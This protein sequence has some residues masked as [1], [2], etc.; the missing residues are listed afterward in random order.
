[1]LLALA[2]I[3]ARVPAAVV[4]IVRQEWQDS[5]RRLQEEIRR[6]RTADALL[7][8]VDVITEELRRRIGQSFTLEEL[9]DAYRGAD[10]WSRDAVAERAPARGLLPL[11]AIVEGA[12]FHLYSRGAIDFRP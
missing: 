5:Y 11:F 1:M 6:P 4:D 8:Q 2:G 12:A 10:A 9:A 3:V 7:A